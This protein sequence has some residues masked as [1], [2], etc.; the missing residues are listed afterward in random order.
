MTT[1]S[2]DND[3]RKTATLVFAIVAMAFGLVAV[4]VAGQAMNRSD[5]A[6]EAALTAGGGTQVTLSEFKITPATIDV[7]KG[8]SIVVTNNG[9]VTHNLGVKGTNLKTEMLAPGTSAKLDLGSL[10][11]GSY[12]AYCQVPGHAEAGMTAQLTV[13]GSSGGMNMG[14]SSGSAAAS[15][16]MTNDQMDAQMAALDKTYPA[17]TEGLGAQLLAPKILPDG[18]K[19]FDLDAKIVQWEVQPGKK[20]EAWTY[21]GT[22]PGPTIKV[23]DGDKVRVV[24]KNDLPESTTVHW[25]GIIV[26]NAMDGVPNFTQ[27]PIKPGQTFTYEFTAHGPAVGMYHSHD[28]AEKQVPNGMAGAFLIGEEPVPP[29]VT[30]SQEIPMVLDDAGTIGLSINGKAYPATAPIQ[31]KLGDWVEIHYFNEGLQIH[32]MHLHGLAQT[33]IAKDGYPV[34]Q[35]YEADTVLIAPG[36]RY[37]VLVHADQPGVWAFHCHILTHA[38]SD[39]GM[40][41]MVTAMIVK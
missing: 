27:P 34:P 24:V 28:H 36:E 26:P 3:V 32:P 40:M 11:A 22:V 15:S 35:P 14:S 10:K 33:V 20:V 2:Q 6:K 18:T 23:N 13:G 37:T 4:I 19:E 16:G 38:E 9:T 25:H 1:R 12:T 21:N 5:S 41:G 31:A 8:G 7:A 29:G 17:K 30:V 39:T